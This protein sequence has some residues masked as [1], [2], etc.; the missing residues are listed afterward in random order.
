[1]FT[2]T[3]KSK[4]KS[5]FR[6]NRYAQVFVT[7]YGWVHAYPMR[8]KG[9]AHEGLSL[10]AQREGVPISFVMDNAKEQIMSEFRHKSKEMGAR[11]KQT[12]P[13]SP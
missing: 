1:M 8:S 4:T 7:Q 11:V 12:E 10:L 3:L 13:Y 6:Q 5:W 2:D 9:K